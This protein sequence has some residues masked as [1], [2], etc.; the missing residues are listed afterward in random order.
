MISK[1]EEGKVQRKNREPVI[2]VEDVWFQYPGGV[3]AL[4]GVTMDVYEG[5]LIAM[6]GQ[7]GGGKTT[8]A[9]HLN[10]LLKP[11]KGRVLV[12]GLDTKDTPTHEIAKRV[13]YVF[14][15]PS[16]QIFESTVW[17]EV[18]FGPKNQGLE[19]EELEERIKWALNLV[20]LEEFVKVNPYDLDYGKMKLLTVASVLAMKPKILVLDEPTTGQDHRGRWILADLCKKLNREEGMT[21]LVITHD[22]RFVAEVA[23]RTILLANG[24][25]MMDA[26][27]REVMGAIDI[28]RKAAIKPTQI[29]ILSSML[30]E[31]GIDISALTV[32]EAVEYFGKML[33]K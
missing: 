29:A 19:G 26:P 7:N 31:K 4:R 15:N 6:I 32:K 3:W 24:K 30:R 16:H 20:G 1:G 5:E 18:A 12:E 11:T 10:G 8:L 27:T 14:Q 9:K 22:M 17:D 28:L 25:I 2:K 33:R 13:G 21:I 23:E